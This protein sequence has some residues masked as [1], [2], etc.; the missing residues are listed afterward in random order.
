MLFEPFT[1]F[2][3]STPVGTVEATLMESH[4]LYFQ[5]KMYLFNY[6]IDFEMLADLGEIYTPSW[7]ST[8]AHLFRDN[9]ERRQYI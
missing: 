4:E 3:N 8:Y 6:V 9:Y 5:K 7:S 2:D 1:L